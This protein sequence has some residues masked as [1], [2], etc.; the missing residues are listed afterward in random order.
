MKQILLDEKYLKT[1]LEY[2]SLY[3][4]DGMVC[5]KSNREDIIKSLRSQCSTG[6][7]DSDG[8]L[9]GYSLIY[10]NEYGVAFF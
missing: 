1:I 4:K 8:K 3:L 6:F 5:M 2:E 9:V 7:I 10:E